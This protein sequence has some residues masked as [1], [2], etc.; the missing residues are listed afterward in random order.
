MHVGTW[1]E[2]AFALVDRTKVIV[3]TRNEATK[4]LLKSE[5]SDGEARGPDLDK[6][7]IQRRLG[8]AFTVKL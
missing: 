7:D 8:V 4:S 5:V 1:H 3:V 2:F 6:K